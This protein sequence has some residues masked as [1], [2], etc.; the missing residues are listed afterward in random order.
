[1]REHWD[2]LEDS[3]FSPP[4]TVSM[5]CILFSLLAFISFPLGFFCLLFIFSSLVCSLLLSFIFLL[6]YFPLTFFLLLVRSLLPSSH[7]WFLLLLPCFTF[8]FGS[9]CFILSFPLPPSLCFCMSILI[10]FSSFISDFPFPFLFHPCS[11]FITFIS[12]PLCLSFSF[13]TSLLSIFFPLPSSCFFFFN[14]IPFPLSSHFI[15][16]HICSPTPT[17]PLWV[18]L[19]SFFIISSSFSYFTFN[20]IP[21]ISFPATLLPHFSL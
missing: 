18:P 4:I 7:F 11:T 17:P 5:I 16:S 10:F 9:S 12:F 2:Q 21:F 1:M 14:L 3:A 15:F 19:V 20:L 8:P 6:I 13:Y